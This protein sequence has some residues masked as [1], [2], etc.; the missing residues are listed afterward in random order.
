DNWSLSPFLAA[1]I[2]PTNRLFA[3]G[4]MQFDF[5]LTSNKIT[6]TELTS[7][8]GFSNSPTAQR[9]VQQF[10]GQ[11]LLPPFTV[12]NRIDEQILMHVDAGVGYWLVR[13]PTAPWITGIAP[14]LELH[15]TTTL[16]NAKIVTLPGDGSL[17]QAP[18]GRVQAEAFPQVGN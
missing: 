5:P 11:F 18:G 13:N 8:P 2:T 10:P 14:S 16:E 1:V 4:F 6:Y 9:L 12:T 17:A 15:Y 3:Q 7:Q